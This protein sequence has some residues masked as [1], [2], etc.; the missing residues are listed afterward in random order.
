M[1]IETNPVVFVLGERPKHKHGDMACFQLCP[2]WAYDLQAARLKFQIISWR[3]QEVERCGDS[4]NG[5]D[6]MVELTQQLHEIHDVIMRLE[7]TGGNS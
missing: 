5:P 6:R 7:G 1:K 2:V 3:M 4:K